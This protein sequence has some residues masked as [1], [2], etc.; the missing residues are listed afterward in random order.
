[1]IDEDAEGERVFV[2]YSMSR[3]EVM[4]HAGLGVWAVEFE[5]LMRSLSFSYVFLFL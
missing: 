3:C 5:R 2:L 4:R 1:M